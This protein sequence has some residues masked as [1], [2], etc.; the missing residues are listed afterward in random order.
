MNAA[1][2]R[3][4]LDP[5]VRTRRVDCDTRLDHI[6]D[7]YRRT[8]ETGQRTLFLLAAV[9]EAYD[10]GDFDLS[11]LPAG[12]AVSDTARLH[13]ALR[14]CLATRSIGGER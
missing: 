12:V 9:L 10:D 6:I 2:K 4:H 1:K 3:R 7:V 13:A 14:E 11:R 5:T 8:D